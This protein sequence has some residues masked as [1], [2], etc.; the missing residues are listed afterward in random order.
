MLYAIFY[1]ANGNGNKLSIKAN[2]NI[3]DQEP[4]FAPLKLKL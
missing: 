2:L 3:K 4:L 1:F